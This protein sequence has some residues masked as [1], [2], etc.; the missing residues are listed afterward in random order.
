MQLLNRPDVNMVFAEIGA[1]SMQQLWDAGIEFYDI[2]T[3]VARFVTSW[4]TSDSD[5]DRVLSTVASLSR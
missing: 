1:G 2:T 3:D 4:Q 5:V